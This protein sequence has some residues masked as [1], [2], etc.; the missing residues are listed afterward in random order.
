MI[1]KKK[2]YS[3]KE[4][5]EAILDDCKDSYRHETY[6]RNLEEYGSID[7]GPVNGFIDDK[8]VYGQRRENIYRLWRNFVIEKRE[9]NKLK[10]R[11]IKEAL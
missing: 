2:K 11:H 9:V 1:I 3:K 8:S 7:Y 4:L 6:A 5:L 10:T